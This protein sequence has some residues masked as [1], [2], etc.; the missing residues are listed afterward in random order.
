[1]ADASEGSDDE[2][3]LPFENN[4]QFV[5]YLYDEYKQDIPLPCIAAHYPKDLVW[6]FGGQRNEDF[7]LSGT[8]HGQ[9]GLIEFL[10]LKDHL[11]QVDK[12]H[13]KEYLW[14]PGSDKVVVFL[15]CEYTIRSTGVSYA[16]E[17]KMVFDYTPVLTAW[18]QRH[19]DGSVPI[20]RVVALSKPTDLKG[21]TSSIYIH[22]V[23]HSSQ[24]G[25]F[26]ATHNR[27][28]YEPVAS[29]FSNVLLFHTQT[30][31]NI[32]TLSCITPP[33][34]EPGSL[35][36]HEPHNAP[37]FTRLLGRN[38]FL[39]DFRGKLV[40]TSIAAPLFLLQEDRSL[41]SA[42]PFMASLKQV[43]PV[44]SFDWS[45]SK[46]PEKTE[47]HNSPIRR[48]R[49]FSR[50][51][52][53]VAPK[54]N[55]PR[56]SGSSP[57]LAFES[58]LPKKAGLSTSPK[59]VNRGRK[60]LRLS[61]DNKSRSEPIPILRSYTPPPQ[62]NSPGCASPSPPLPPLSPSN[63]VTFDPT[64][65]SEAPSQRDAEPV[66]NPEQVDTEEEL[67]KPVVPRSLKEICRD[68]S[69]T[70]ESPLH[71]KLK[72][73]IDHDEKILQHV[74]EE[75]P[76]GRKSIIPLMNTMMEIAYAPVPTDSPFTVLL[77]GPDM[78]SLSAHLSSNNV[79]VLHVET[80]SEAVFFA[81]EDYTAVLVSDLLDEP[82]DAFVAKMKS[83]GQCP[84][85]Y[86]ALW[87]SKPS[88]ERM[89]IWKKS[90]VRLNL[91]LHASTSSILR[92]LNNLGRQ[93]L[94]RKIVHSAILSEEH[95]L[96]VE[97][98]LIQSRNH[99]K[100]RYEVL[101][102][103]ADIM[104]K[105]RNSS[106]EGIYLLVQE[107]KEL[108]SMLSQNMEMLNNMNAERIQD[109]L[110]TKDVGRARAGS[111]GRSLKP[112]KPAVDMTS[113]H[114]STPMQQILSRLAQTTTLGTADLKNVLSGL[115]QNLS[116]LDLH[117]PSVEK[118]EAL[119]DDDMTKSYLVGS[120]L[121]T[122]GAKKTKAP[123]RRSET[124]S[125]EIQ[126][127]V[128]LIAGIPLGINGLRNLRFDSLEWTKDNL[129]DLVEVI[130]KDLG[131]IDRFDIPVTKLRNFAKGL[132]K[133]Y[134]NNPYH[135]WHHAFDVMQMC[136]VLLKEGAGNLLEPI[137][138]LGLLTSALC[139]DLNHPGLNN[140][141]Q[142]NAQTDL[143][144]V[145][146]D[147]SVL[148]NLHCSRAFYL[149]KELDCNIFCNLTSEEAVM[150][151]RCMV[152][153]ILSTD[154][155]GHFELMT[156][157]ANLV[158]ARTSLPNCEEDKIFVTPQEI[159]LLINVLLHTADI[160]NMGRPSDIARKWSDLVFQEGL[161]QGDREKKEKLP[162]SPY[163]NREDSNQ[164][165]LSLM[166]IDYVVSP[167]FTK[168]VR[169]LPNMAPLM[170]NLQQNRTIWER[171][172]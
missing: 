127:S 82:I 75:V 60:Q 9:T 117:R 67:S 140:N 79:I 152:S 106:L 148:E 144:I 121:S 88:R 12:W 35:A 162:I 17:V 31:H 170:Q 28:Q 139:H 65:Y 147:I 6:T 145:Y 161:E 68:L 25:N 89:Q 39:T 116:S 94:M 157:F 133:G 98:G 51:S 19:G 33:T 45:H 163:M 41:P 50:D 141:Y 30:C 159:Q 153:A 90:G 84:T 101:A 42:V 80:S 38:L 69:L 150:M 93:K 71:V 104:N 76:Q 47:Q 40:D 132:T 58:R 119:D 126:S 64:L 70:T 168:V 154:M 46:G 130:Y 24:S 87:S 111:I 86:V 52:V 125:S 62:S 27:Y 11:I 96:I 114:T 83:F 81:N 57:D 63:R 18:K 5:K 55:V 2:Y 134:L 49:S 97:N 92:H 164:A 20:S 103:H 43:L 3:T 118:I 122:D 128:I 102:G 105:F 137:Y 85:I 166:F 78:S 171:L 56:L 146:N 160:S 23:F 131:L 110:N 165:K 59:L 37:S 113:E 167:L 4:K 129:C 74:Y 14:E 66:V 29:K 138:Q 44:I 136:F 16:A 15:D 120:F 73:M 143:S 99:H 21:Q 54:E 32:P 53:S 124:V 36:T 151:R 10:T 34:V 22:S 112:I 155:T 156:K 61:L 169:L 142:I 109:R 158:E 8:W 100:Q 26:V 91:P 77:V 135:N 72:N 108:R 95:A 13:R 123:L 7:P 115:S 1:M 48:E 172:A 149:L 107:A